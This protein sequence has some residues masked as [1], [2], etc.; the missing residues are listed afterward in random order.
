MSVP[1]VSCPGRRRASQHLGWLVRLRCDTL[2]QGVAPHG[3]WADQVTDRGENPASSAPDPSGDRSPWTS[4]DLRQE[5]Q[6]SALIERFLAGGAEDALEALADLM[7]PRL[8]RV[9]PAVLDE[10]GALIP[11]DLASEWLTEIAL[12]AGPHDR[13]L[14][15]PFAHALEFMHAR[16]RALVTALSAQALPWEQD[17]APSLPAEWM[18]RL[19]LDH[20]QPEFVYVNLVTSHRLDE[21][22]RRVLRQ[23]QVNGASVDEAAERLGLPADSV[24]S[25]YRKGRIA[26]VEALERLARDDP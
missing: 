15:H 1:G 24:A 21:T 25:C 8:D 12:G 4:D 22:T 10:I 3:R 18:L 7:A 11:L 17:F 14:S 26:V 5:A 23:I 2:G 13:A 20:A 6:A 16:G 9:E 19:S